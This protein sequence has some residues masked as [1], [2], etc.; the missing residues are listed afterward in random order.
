MSD[1]ATALFA[2]SRLRKPA[3]SRHS[4]MRRVALMLDAWRSRRI[5]AELEPRLVERAHAALRRLDEAVANSAFLAGER[6]SLADLSLVAY[7]RWSHEGGIERSAYPA[8]R[9]WITRTEAALG[10]TD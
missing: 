3:Q 1:H 6:V 10:I 8:L 7:T 5:L 4:V 9:S 2:F